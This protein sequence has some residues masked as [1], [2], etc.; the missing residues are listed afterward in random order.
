MWINLLITIYS[1]FQNIEEAGQPVFVT[2]NPDNIPENTLLKWSTGH[3]IPSV[4]AFKASVE[5]DNIQGKR[6]IWFS[7]AYQGTFLLI[8]LINKITLIIISLKASMDLLVTT[9][10]RFETLIVFGIFQN[11]RTILAYMHLYGKSS[12]NI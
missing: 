1:N 6:R 8:V 11:L 4:S 5:L 7:G 12:F 9:N 2:L 3:P 10:V